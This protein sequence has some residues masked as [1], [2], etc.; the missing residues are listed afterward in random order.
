MRLDE[1]VI[2]E[3][4]VADAGRRE[5][6]RDIGPSPPTPRTVTREPFRRACKSWPVS[7]WRE[8]NEKNSKLR[9]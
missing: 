3:Q 4:E 8:K 7:G 9:R 6:K 5:L 1:V 2:D